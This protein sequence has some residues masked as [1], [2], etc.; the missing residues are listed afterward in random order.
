MTNLVHGA[1]RWSP[2]FND[3]IV[4]ICRG[5]HD[6]LRAVA[7]CGGVP[8]RHVPKPRF[9]DQVR[10]HGITLSAELFRP[11]AKFES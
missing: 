2:S 6:P 11:D 9:L 7:P 4:A 5:L 10:A 3:V 8:G 1:G